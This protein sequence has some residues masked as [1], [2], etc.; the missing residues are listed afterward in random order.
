MAEFLQKKLK[1]K[2]ETIVNIF[3]DYIYTSFNEK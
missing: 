1:G 2:K 3:I